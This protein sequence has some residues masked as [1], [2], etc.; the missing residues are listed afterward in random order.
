MSV[1]DRGLHRARRGVCLSAMLAFLSACTVVQGN[2]AAIED[3][4]AAPAQAVATP[5]PAVPAST[6][7]ADD[8]MMAT[9]SI[10][11]V[12]SA[13]I[14]I[15]LPSPKH[16]EVR[17][18]SIDPRAGISTLAGGTPVAALAGIYLKYNSGLAEAESSRL[19][20]PK[21]VRRI[22]KDLRYSEPV[23]MS[24][25]W[26]AVHAMTAAQNT[27]FAQGVREE[28]R[29]KGQSRILALLDDDNYIL[30]LP[31]ASAVTSEIMAAI[32]QND[33]RMTRLRARF[34]DVAQK[35]QRQKWGMSDPLPAAPEAVRAASA[36]TDE[37]IARQALNAFSPVSPA[38]AYSPTVMKRIL[39]TAAR[40][41]MAVP[42]SAST[43]AA[44]DETARCL[45]WA[46]LNLNQCVA[47]AHFP[48][49]EA[50]CTGTH[51]IEEVRA[52]WAAAL[53]AR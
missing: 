1:R 12:A 33:E 40:Q 41:V 3:G 18:A 17:V 32:K 23:S 51:A 7:S 14:P 15:P 50:W 16:R 20:T 34:L 24:E 8:A 45:N 38:H 13:Q 26:Y 48:S 39:A 46:K 27:A 10:G 5:A 36:A 44:N 9:G 22:L 4:K 6:A 30:T 11:S 31:G 25:G 47:A 37:G 28:M 29:S 43:A 35:F 53:P 21:E 19:N 52:C 49:E 42:A 2:T